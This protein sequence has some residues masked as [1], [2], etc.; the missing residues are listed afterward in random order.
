MRLQIGGGE[1][2]VRRAETWNQWRLFESVQLFESAQRIFPDTTVA[3]NGTSMK[4]F[5]D[6][7]EESDI[8]LEDP[9]LILGKGPSYATRDQYDTRTFRTL[10]LNHVVREQ[11][12]DVAHMIDCDVVDACRQVLEQNAQVLVMPWIP[13]VRNRPGKK[14]L[15]ELGP[16]EH[17]PESN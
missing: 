4:N 16:G 11:A 15:M 6:W 8:G 12:V 10:S 3:S 1:A 2:I 5:F 14:N 9:W 13:H 17:N 7:F